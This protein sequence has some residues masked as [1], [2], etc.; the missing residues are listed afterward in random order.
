MVGP[1]AK[2]RR[3]PRPT[4]PR[5]PGSGR[6]AALHPR[7][8]S[9]GTGASTA[10]SRCCRS[11][12]WPRLFYRWLSLEELRHLLVA[13]PLGAVRVPTAAELR[14]LWLTVSSTSAARWA[15]WPWSPWPRPSS[16]TGCCPPRAGPAGAAVAAAGSMPEAP[17]AAADRWLPVTAGLAPGGLAGREGTGLRAVQQRPAHR[18]GPSVAGDAA[19]LPRLRPR[20]GP[21]PRVRTTGRSGI[22]FHTSESD[23]WPLEAA[24]NENLRDSSAAACCATSAATGSTT[25]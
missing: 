6:Q 12:P 2:V 17:A 22:L 14:R 21:R 3:S 11:P 25:T 13:E 16:C 1:S 15:P 8:R 4:E 7:R 19:P 9:H 24:F 18:H 5:H 23:V 10:V 20:S